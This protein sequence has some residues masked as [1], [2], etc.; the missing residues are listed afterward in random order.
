MDAINKLAKETSKIIKSIS[1]GKGQA[2]KAKA[3]I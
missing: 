1:L 3:L 2:E